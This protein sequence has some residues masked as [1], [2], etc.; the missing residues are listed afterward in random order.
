MN[1]EPTTGSRIELVN[2]PMLFK[3]K[4]TAADKTGLHHVIERGWLELHESGADV[5][6]EAANRD[7]LT[8]SK[9]L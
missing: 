8:D 9:A 1:R 6:K 4:A 5:K 2:Y 3:L 7:S